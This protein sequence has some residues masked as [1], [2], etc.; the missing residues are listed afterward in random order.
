MRQKTVTK[1]VRIAGV[2]SKLPM[3]QKTVYVAAF[4]RQQISK[5]PMRQKTGRGIFGAA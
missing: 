4:E 2:L 3:R 1:V 5:L